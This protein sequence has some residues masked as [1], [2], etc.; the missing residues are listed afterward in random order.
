[1]FPILLALGVLM[2]PPMPPPAP[3]QYATG[4]PEQ[5]LL[6]PA[7]ESI[8]V[9]LEKGHAVGLALLASD[10]IATPQGQCAV[11]FAAAAVGA[12][13]PVVTTIEA[14]KRGGPWQGIGSGSMAVPLVTAPLDDGQGVRL[15][16]SN[17][18]AGPVVV[19]PDMTRL[20]VVAL[21]C[22]APGGG[23]V[24]LEHQRGHF[25]WL[26]NLC[27]G[28]A[29]SACTRELVDHYYAIDAA[30]ADAV[31]SPDAPPPDAFHRAVPRLFIHPTSNKASRATPG[32]DRSPRPGPGALVHHGEA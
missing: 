3:V 15:V 31:L 16:V 12:S 13:G 19:W 27:G 2:A 5:P 30:L 28:D 1:M 18:G 8:A 9:S 20:S 14:G 17:D 6:I 23:G 11:T 24:A 29:R 4:S 26:S 10:G 7:G 22:V 25:A 32:L 21:D